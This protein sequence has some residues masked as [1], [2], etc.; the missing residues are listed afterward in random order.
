MPQLADGSFCP[1]WISRYINVGN[2]EADGYAMTGGDLRR[3]DYAARR[4]KG[5]GKRGQDD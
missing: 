4:Y 1:R 5:K 2:V 3:I